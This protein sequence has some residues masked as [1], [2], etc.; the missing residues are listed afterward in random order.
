MIA[1]VGPGG[2]HFGTP[3]T[4]ARFEQEFYQPFLSD[5]LNYETWRAAGEFDAA[6]R[7]ALVWQE[8]LEAYEPPKLDSAVREELLSFIGRREKELEG[9]NLYDE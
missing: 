1:E 7:A 6:Q 2:H 8:L 9:V 3:H 4:R 5:R